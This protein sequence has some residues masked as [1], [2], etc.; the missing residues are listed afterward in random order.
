MLLPLLFRQVYHDLLKTEE[1]F[2]TEL[3]LA[4]DYYVRTFSDPTVPTE[5]QELKNE[6]TLNVRELYNFHAKYV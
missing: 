1:E 6:L 4:I 3:Q 2:V 5:V